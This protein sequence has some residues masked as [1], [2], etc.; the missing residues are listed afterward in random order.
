MQSVQN[1]IGDLLG[2]QALLAHL[3]EAIQDHVLPH[4][5]MSQV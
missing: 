4:I 3:Q 2:G 1:G 5:S